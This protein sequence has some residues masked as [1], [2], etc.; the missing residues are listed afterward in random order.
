MN[1]LKKKEMFIQILD[2]VGNELFEQERTSVL[3]M[4]LMPITIKIEWQVP[5]Q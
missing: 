2:S 1:K 5:F 4:L 3:R